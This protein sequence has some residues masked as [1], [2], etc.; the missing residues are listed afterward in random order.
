[1]KIRVLLLLSFSFVF[2][3]LPAQSNQYYVK[4]SRDTV[5]GKLNINTY[6]DNSLKM[7][8]KTEEGKNITVLPNNTL[9]AY[10]DED[11]LYRAVIYDNQRLFM[12]EVYFGA[13][14]IFNYTRYESNSGS[15][16]TSKVFSKGGTESIELSNFNFKKQVKTFLSDCPEIVS[17][18]DDKKY[19]YKNLLEIGL[20]YDN[21]RI[22]NPEPGQLKTEVKNI[23]IE[24]GKLRTEISISNDIE[25]K[26]EAFEILKD[27][28]R[29]MELND[30]VPEYLWSALFE[31]IELNSDLLAKSKQIQISYK[32]VN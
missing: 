31:T 11:H 8:F 23:I 32:Q 16:I 30:N 13:L 17:G 29:R 12:Q 21:C 19:K 7:L 4:L 3:L 5:Y 27:I 14:S 18:I 10:Y 9:M 25:N 24:L 20:A 6:R 22:E 28:E 2:S 15:I 26:D 1:M